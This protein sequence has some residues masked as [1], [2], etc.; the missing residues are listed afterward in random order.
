[1][2]GKLFISNTEAR[3]HV[4]FEGPGHRAS[5]VRGHAVENRITVVD[6]VKNRI[7]PVHLNPH[8]DFSLPHG[9]ELPAVQ[10]ARSLALPTAMVPSPD[11]ATLYVAALG[12]NVVAALP[13][14]ELGT[15]R[16]NPDATRH[17]EVPA[18]PAGLALSSD[19]ARLYVYSHVEHRIS[20]IDTRT[21]RVLTQHV[22]FTPDALQIRKG[23]ALLYDARHTSGNGNMAC[24]SCHTFSD[25]DHLAWDL[26]NPDERPHPNP[27][28]YVAN[29]P[30]TT[31]SFHPMKGPM[32]TQTLRGM[33]GNGPLHWRGDRPGQNR[34]VVR[35][36][37]E[38]LEEAAFKEFNGA[39]VD[40]NG[41]ASPLPEA[42]MQAF[43]DFALAL[44]MP[45]NPVRALDGTLSPDEQAGRDIYMNKNDMTLLGSCNHCHTLDPANKR[46]GTS[47][48]M[49]FEGFRITGDFKVPQLR[50]MYQKLGMFGF[51]LEGPAMG[52]QIRG[53]GFAHDGAI[54]RLENFFA[55]PVFN[56][57]APVAAPGG[58]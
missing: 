36:R 51:S 41:R 27:N 17:I 39:F 58:R 48:L 40:L 33:A 47:G 11:G 5:T 34:K 32:S 44:A 1:M 49:T 56:F 37:L 9:Q 29:S 12:S 2:S 53:F 24:A 30:R 31:F 26:G 42:E 28:A 18:G 13:T 38:S 45:P 55:D 43:T 50:N 15:G 4:R 52:A 22:M 35:G 23:R 3:N 25:M 10:K 46:F 21:R 19:G 20:L 14:A 57:P 54:D 7:D 16:F 6:P 8:I